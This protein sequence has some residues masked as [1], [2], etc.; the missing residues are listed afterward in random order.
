MDLEV[1]LQVNGKA[2]Q[3]FIDTRTTL[4]DALRERL[5]Q[6]IDVGGDVSVHRIDLHRSGALVR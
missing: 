5:V 4:L 3:L 1:T 2:H 6:H